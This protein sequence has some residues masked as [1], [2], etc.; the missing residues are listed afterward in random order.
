MTT[1]EM[2]ENPLDPAINPDLYGTMRT[3]RSI[4]FLIDVVGI[5][6]LMVVASVIV[7]V[8]G[9]VTLGLGWLLYFI[10][11]PAVAVLY[12]L[13]A[14]AGG[15]PR[16]PGMAFAGI[17]LRM[18]YGDRPDLLIGLAHPILFYL[19]VTFLT[20]FI[21]L[22]SFLSARKRLA[23]DIVLGTVVVDSDALRRT[24]AVA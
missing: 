20:P 22:V 8:L 12:Y 2:G 17:E 3:R 10:L 14:F 16:T 4:A 1:L 6:V 9:V 5:T 21:V 18:W 11:W 19:S 24:V 15:A 7:F 23:H 13:L